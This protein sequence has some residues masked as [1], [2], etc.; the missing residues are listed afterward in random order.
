M[1]IIGGG[2]LGS[3][4]ACSLAHRATENGKK[5]M[6]NGKITQLTPET[7]KESYLI[8]FL[9]K[10]LVLTGNIS[11]VLPEYLSKW[12]TERVRDGNISNF[13]FIKQN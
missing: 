7:G 8:S 6:P 3:E 1:T 9:L 13:S 11:K 10:F 5:G 2:F 4:L 12:A